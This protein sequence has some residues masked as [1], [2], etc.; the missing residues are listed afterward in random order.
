[1]SNHIGAKLLQ[2]KVK[3]KTWTVSKEKHQRKDSDDSEFLIR[4]QRLEARGKAFFKWSKKRIVNLEFYVR[5]KL[6]SRS[7]GEID[8]FSDEEKLV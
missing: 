5:Q 6:P 1:M 8:T 2:V 7:K 4:N 3:E